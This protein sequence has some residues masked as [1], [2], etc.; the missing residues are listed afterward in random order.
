[1]ELSQLI[2]CL[3]GTRGGGGIIRRPGKKPQ[4]GMWQRSDEEDELAELEEQLKAAKL[5]E[6]ALKVAQKE[7]KVCVSPLAVSVIVW[8]ILALL[9][10]TGK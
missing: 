2:L 8:S 4:R 1:M 5:P 10:V 6:H 9:A 3:Q 7:L